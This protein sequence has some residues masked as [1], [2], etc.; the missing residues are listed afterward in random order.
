M[1][2]PCAVT[3]AIELAEQFAT[4][5]RQRQVE[6]FDPWLN[7]AQASELI[8]FQR[9]VEGLRDDESAVRAALT[10]TV[11]NGQVEGQVNRLKML[12]RQMYGRDGT[13]LLTR[14]LL[15]AS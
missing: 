8:P 6:Q 9:F 1:A 2:Q 4:M 10:S 11:S 13:E 5:V 14:R 12:K 7:Q 3:Q 15:L